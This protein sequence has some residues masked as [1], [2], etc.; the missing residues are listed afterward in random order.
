MN[1]SIDEVEQLHRALLQRDCSID[2]AIG[3]FLLAPIILA[4]FL[5]GM[6]SSI[7]A[8]VNASGMTVVNFAV[9]SI[10]GL[11]IYG[12]LMHFVCKVRTLVIVA[13]QSLLF[14]GLFAFFC[15]AIIQL[16]LEG[17]VPVMGSALAYVFSQIR[18]KMLKTHVLA[19]C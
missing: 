4:C 17:N 8:S 14:G 16:G 9:L 2:A 19:F 18:I 7:P 13:S 1:P 15:L 10:L 6:E 11:V 5:P 3:S 12:L